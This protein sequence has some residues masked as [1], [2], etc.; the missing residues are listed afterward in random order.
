MSFPPGGELR[1]RRVTGMGWWV[2]GYNL[3]L[4]KTNQRKWTF[5]WHNYTPSVQ[6]W[7]I[8]NRLY[9]ASFPTRQRAMLALADSMMVDPPPPELRVKIPRLRYRAKGR[10]DSSCGRWRVERSA[11]GVWRAARS[12]DPFGFSVFA[13]TLGE[14][15]AR[16]WASELESR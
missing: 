3:I 10:Y 7:L 12:D 15:R 1:L 16:M 13:H 11:K 6:D 9:Q 14:L 5:L 8:P 4:I 2:E